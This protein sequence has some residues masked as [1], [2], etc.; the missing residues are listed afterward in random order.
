MALDQGQV[1]KRVYEQLRLLKLRGVAMNCVGLVD[2][3]KARTSALEDTEETAEA[4]AAGQMKRCVTPSGGVGGGTRVPIAILRALVLPAL[5]YCTILHD[6]N[7][8]SQVKSS[9]V[10]SS[11]WQV[12]A[13]PCSAALGTLARRA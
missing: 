7:K 13:P 6:M 8:S 10:K 9:Q 4:R 2:T 3:L 11:Q 5:L 1:E 12:H